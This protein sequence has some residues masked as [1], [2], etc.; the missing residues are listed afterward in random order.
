MID[1]SLNSNFVLNKKKRDCCFQVVT[2]ALELVEL[3]AP[4]LDSNFDL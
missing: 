1:R 4:I 2:T 3:P